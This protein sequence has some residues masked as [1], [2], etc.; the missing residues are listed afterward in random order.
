MFSNKTGKLIIVTF[1]LMNRVTIILVIFLGFMIVQPALACIDPI[2][3]ME[4]CDDECNDEQG[5]CNDLCNPFLSC[6][7]CLGFTTDTHNEM[8]EI[9]KLEKTEYSEHSE[10]PILGQVIEIFRPPIAA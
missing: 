7:T 6:D 2:F 8:V 10:S 1:V 9:L 5:E 4:L 3:D